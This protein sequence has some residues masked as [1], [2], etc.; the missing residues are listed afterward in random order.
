MTLEERFMLV[1]HLKKKKN[2]ADKATSQVRN[3]LRPSTG[4]VFKSHH[5]PLN[6]NA[7]FEHHLLTTGQTAL[8]PDRLSEV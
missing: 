6:L 2:A 4:K 5:N 1:V 8:V 3:C 7:A